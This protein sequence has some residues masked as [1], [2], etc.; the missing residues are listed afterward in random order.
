MD[1]DD[2]LDLMLLAVVLIRSKKKKK[3]RKVWVQEMFKNREKYGIHH[4]VT[5]MQ[6]SNREAYFK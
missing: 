3:K 6:I 2:E 5:E 4:L 1:S